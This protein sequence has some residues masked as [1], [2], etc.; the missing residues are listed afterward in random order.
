MSTD[1]Q[2][3]Q[4]A[5]DDLQMDTKQAASAGRFLLSDTAAAAAADTASVA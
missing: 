4:T 5:E 3:E 2:V 1:V